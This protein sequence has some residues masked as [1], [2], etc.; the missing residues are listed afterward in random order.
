MSEEFRYSVT[1]VVFED[2]GDV[3]VPR[4]YQALFDE[5]CKEIDILPVSTPMWRSSGR[6][7]YKNCMLSKQRHKAYTR[8]LL[9][10]EDEKK[11]SIGEEAMLQALGRYHESLRMKKYVEECRAT[12][13]RKRAMNGSK[14]DIDWFAIDEE[15]A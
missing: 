13:E 6:Y 12:L 9:C 8:S 10:S 1:D 7:G 11:I 3:P 2:V 14:V 5:Y 15:T 4:E